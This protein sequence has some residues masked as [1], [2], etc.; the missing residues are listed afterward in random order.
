[1]EFWDRVKWD[2]RRVW[3][4]ARKVVLRRRIGDRWEDAGGFGL[5]RYPDY[6]T[7]VEHQKTKF[8]ALRSSSVHR[9]E[10]RFYPALVER[11]AGMPLDFHGRSVL[12]LAARQGTEVRAFIGQGA[13]AV[14][15]DLNPGPKN[16]YV[17]VGD[18]HDLQFAD[19]SVDFVFTNSLDHAYDLDRIVAE[20]RRVLRPDGAFIVE[21]NAAGEEEAASAGA[22]EATVWK[23]VD[24]LVERITAHGFALEARR[25]FDV[26]WTGEQLTL[27][28]IGSP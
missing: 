21:A 10:R 6:E 9:H 22:Y 26:P 1:M 25:P 17:V 4:Q 13:F 20:V 3:H 15:I 19:G 12:C 23:D 2:V 11:L 5:R 7:Y 16:R 8:S 28:R 24:A 27:R 14:G 18:F